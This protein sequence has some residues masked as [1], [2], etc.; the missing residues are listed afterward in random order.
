MFGATNS[1]GDDKGFPI[2]RTTDGKIVYI[3]PELSAKGFDSDTS[4]NKK[5]LV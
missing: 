5:T 4:I 3:F 1:L 2:G